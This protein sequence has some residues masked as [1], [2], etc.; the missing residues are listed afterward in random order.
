MSRAFGGTG[1][2]VGMFLTA[3]PLLHGADGDKI[4]G[5]WVWKAPSGDSDQYWSITN[6]KGAWA[7][8]AVKG[9]Y[10][11]GGVETG[12]FVGID[13]KFAD[14]V[15]T[16]THK[17]IQKPGENLTDNTPVKIAPAADV[18]AYRW[19]KDYSKGPRT[20]ARSDA[21]APEPKA[22]VGEPKKP[23]PKKEGRF[24]G[25][26]KGAVEG[27]DLFWTIKYEDEIWSV[28]VVYKKG[29]AE[30][31]SFVGSE[32]KYGDG[33]LAFKRKF[34][35]KPSTTMLDDQAMVLK[36]DGANLNYSFAAPGSPTRPLEPNK[37]DPP[38]VAGKEPA[39]K[40]V[41]RFQGVWEGEVEEFK[42]LWDIRQKDGKW[43]VAVEYFTKNAKTGA[44]T[45]VG[46]YVGIETEIK[47]GHLV[48]ETKFLKKPTP[49]WAGGKITCQL[50]GESSFEYVLETGGIKKKA[51]TVTRLKK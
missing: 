14:G 26:W 35:K 20:L 51:L 3:A 44:L 46:S 50:L 6:E 28:K 5:T 49:G 21:K 36:V 4:V 23:D 13:V 39:K 25:S 2:L 34:V 11:K 1:F 22:V 43:E 10:T 17:Y 9:W 30:V 41:T 18:L 24:V 27:Y 38:A 37:E 47:D 45:P 31:G 19:G 32:V 16:Y 12:S 42:T 7:A 33:A 29:G 48:F 8:W 15:L 40:D